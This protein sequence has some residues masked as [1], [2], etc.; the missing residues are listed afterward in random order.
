MAKRRV[1]EIAKDRGMTTQELADRLREAGVQFKSNLSS[2]EES[3]VDRVLSASAT[4]QPEAKAPAVEKQETGAKAPAEKSAQSKPADTAA[5]R[6]SAP[7]AG[8]KDAAGK[9]AGTKDAGAKD[10]AGKTKREQEAPAKPTGQRRPVDVS[11]E[12]KRKGRRLKSIR[13]EDRPTVAAPDVPMR[14]GVKPSGTVLRKGE[15]EKL[16]KQR[17]EEERKRRQ[18]E[19]EAQKA[20]KSRAAQ[21][22]PAKR[23]EA[24]SAPAGSRP[25]T[26][27]RGAAPSRAPRPAGS[28]VA[29]KEHTEEAEGRRRPAGKSRSRRRRG[30]DKPARRRVVIDSQ[31][32]RKTGRAVKG[33]GADQ[34]A[35][36]QTPTKAK[37]APGTEEPVR[38]SS[39]ATVK[40]VSEA[41]E[42]PSS[43]II[44]SMMKLGEMVTIT[45]S[46]SDDAIELIAAEH[47]RQVEIKHAEEES[48][49]P[50]FED[51]EE[52]LVERA[53]VVTVM[54]HVDHGKTSLLDAIRQ[55][56]VAAGEAGGITQH[57]GA[58]QVHH[59]G[60]LVTFIDTPGHEA[61]TAMRARG[62]KV[63]DVAV[64]VV[65]AND[66]VMPQTVEAIDHAKAA[67]VPIVVA[68]NKMDLPDA[69]PD[70]VRQQLSEYGLVPEDWGGDTI[71]V[72]VSAKQRMNLDELMD[73]LL[74]V[75]DV[76]E[77]KANPKAPASGVIV[78]S[79]LDVGRG[80]LATMLVQ[81]GTLR[82]GDALWSGESYGKVK[83]MFDFKGEQ[84]REAGPS[85]PVQIL[86]FDTVP[87]AGDF[88]L[89]TKDEREARQKAEQ[90]SARLRMEQLAKGRAG[91]ASLE[92]FYA[93]LKEGEVKELNLIIKGDVGGSVEALEE[94][95]TGVSHEEV[96]VRVIRSGV[97][98]VNESDVM[99]GA[100]S[101]AVIIGFNV[102]PSAGAKALAEQ[103]GVDI[104]TYRVIYKA[105]EDIQ[106]ALV[107]ML[108]PEQ[109]E[110]E[111]GAAEVRQTFKSSR[112]GT[113][114]GCLV[115][116]GRITRNA[117]VRLVR[118]GNI[119]YEG[120]LASL[121]RFQ[122][123]VREVTAGYECGLV[124]DGY[125]D[126]REGDVIEAY[127]IRE[128][129]RT[130]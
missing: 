5:P 44:M 81:R 123:D 18:K 99:L 112:V 40:D 91:A 48:G 120:T 52:D 64:I 102:R 7:D 115:Q 66:G 13:H 77:L 108:E 3:E 96:K 105:I 32:G 41:L 85:V 121:K 42:I 60:R 11:K 130:S 6:G 56:E 71:M 22:P 73:M 88:A 51:A 94:A 95:L 58:Y 49:E 75:A 83:A 100:A 84:L 36:A 113:I 79:Q 46:L 10:A 54:G 34:E 20:Q 21:A 68:I 89:V 27:P 2:L 23:G 126:V 111:L 12:P 43:E 86:G 67:E 103:E 38:I 47:D 114:A 4:P 109:V 122:E 78:E 14:K 124:I 82:V 9:D 19:Q 98:G 29:P 104:R 24:P 128:V 33:K 55:T 17:Q 70:R 65:A 16:L 45:Q 119:V 101:N 50:V 93:R 15:E 76:Q 8:A 35:E 117:R 25:A 31:A 57:I 63:T 26:S 53:P 74:L 127:E 87:V 97:G 110:E 1:Y 62:A 30:E 61:F 92:D 106:A 125:D 37:P 80:P 72:S 107:G 69:N 28:P 129:A 39:G 116:E 59:E 118:D 90:R